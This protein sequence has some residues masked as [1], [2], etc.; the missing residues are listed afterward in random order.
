MAGRRRQ[1]VGR[2]QPGT[3]NCASRDEGRATLL[4]A[5][6][7]VPKEATGVSLASPTLLRSHAPTLIRGVPPHPSFPRSMLEIRP[8]FRDNVPMATDTIKLSDELATRIRDALSPLRPEK[9]I[10]FGSYAGAGRPRTATS[11]STS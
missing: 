1:A 9:V 10:L 6:R 5:S 3:D 11:T 8:A 7:C 4:P 2:R